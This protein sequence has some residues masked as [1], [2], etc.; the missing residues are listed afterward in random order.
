VRST[1]AMTPERWNTI[2]ARLQDVGHR[3]TDTDVVEPHRFVARGRVD[4]TLTGQGDGQSVVRVT[5]PDQ[6]GLLSA[7]CRWFAEHD[8]SVEAASIATVD[9]TAKDIFTVQGVCDVDGLV[10]H[11]SSRGRSNPAQLLA[12]VWASAGRAF[13]GVV[14]AT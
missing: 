6:I 4:V 1:A 7:V 8:V 12:T 14:S 13:E 11:L 10:D 9:G 2:G 5:A 3:P